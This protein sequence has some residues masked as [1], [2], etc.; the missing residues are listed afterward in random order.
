[1]R[2]RYSAFATGDEAYLLASWHPS[3][4]PV[5]LQLDP[6]RQWLRLEVL[7]TSGGGLLE[8]TG[9]VEFRA[10]SRL[11]GTADVLHERSRFAREGGLWRYLGSVSA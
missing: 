2:S 6:G 10:Y 1:M 11:A 8:P 5:T 7:A 9:T 3:T 4:R